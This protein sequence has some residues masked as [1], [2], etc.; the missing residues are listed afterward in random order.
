MLAWLGEAL[1][2]AGYIVAAVNHHGNTSAESVASPEGFMLWWERALDLSK[3][4]DHLLADP[5]LGGVIDAN[6]VGAAGFSLGGYSVVAVAGARVSLAQ[7]QQFCAD[8]PSDASCGPQPEY[9]EALAQFERVRMRPAIQ[10]SLSRHGDSYEDVRVRAV[11]AIAP[12]GSWL[13]SASL[14]RIA[15]PIRVVVGDQ[16]QTAPAATNARRISELAPG[17]RL[18]LLPGVSHYTFLA[19]CLPAGTSALPTLC[20]EQSGVDRAAVHR[21]VSADA[22]AFF[23]STLGIR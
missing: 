21:E 7:W 4:L 16:D 15:V 3:V 10:A 11:Y 9:P 2:R 23:D 20:R 14:A 22:V 8:V 6:R 12:V 18:S 13:T 1:A 17:A 19:E 5:M